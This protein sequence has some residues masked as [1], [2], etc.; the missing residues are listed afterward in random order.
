MEEL[1]VLDHRLHRLSTTLG[2]HHPGGRQF[3]AG[4]AGAVSCILFVIGRN[5]LEKATISDVLYYFKGQRSAGAIDQADRHLPLPATAHIPGIPS[6]DTLDLHGGWYDATGDYGIHLSHLSFSSYFN[7][8]QVSF[9][10]YSLLKTNELLA[11]R[12]GTDYRQILRRIMD[13]A[14]YGAD[15]L[16]RLQAKGGSTIVVHRRTRRR[17][18]GER[19]HD[20]AGTAEL[21]H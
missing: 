9:V 3:F 14:T 18:S 4:D 20:L 1:A 11:N 13:E 21:S 16:V 8:Q 10:L 19:P 6:P 15:Y 2:V 17:E 7:P 12:P 5:V